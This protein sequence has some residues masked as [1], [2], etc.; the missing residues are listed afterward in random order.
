MKLRYCSRVETRLPVIFATDDYVGE[1]TVVN[2]SVPG[3]AIASKQ[4]VAPGA[5]LEM[6][7]LFPDF[8]PPLSVGL[9]RV[10]W[11]Q[12]RRFGVEFIRMPGEDQVRLGRFVKSPI[13][14]GTDDKRQR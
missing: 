5:Y 6:K 8:S 1:G 2:V 3:C 13:P 11:R 14:L 7:V 10:R 4:D 12:N 9:A